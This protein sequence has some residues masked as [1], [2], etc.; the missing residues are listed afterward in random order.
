MARRHPVR[1]G[2]MYTMRNVVSHYKRKAEYVHV[3]V[4]VFFLFLFCFESANE[5]SV[6]RTLAPEEVKHYSKVCSG[7]ERMYSDCA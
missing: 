3:Y 2:H 7:S 1:T 4:F 5:N 6:C